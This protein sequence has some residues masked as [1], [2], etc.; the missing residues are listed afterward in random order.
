MIRSAI[1]ALIISMGFVVPSALA[2]PKDAAELL[3]KLATMPGLSAS[4]EE[5][6]TLKLLR[7]PLVST[8][9]LYFFK[10]RLTRV[11]QTPKPS[12]VRIGPGG[13]TILDGSKSQRVDLTGRPEIDAF[14]RSFARLLGGDLA[15][16]TSDFQM[17][18]STTKN[19]WTL[20]LT[21]RSTRLLKLISAIELSGV[22]YGVET[23]VVRETSGNVS[24]TTIRN[25]DPARQFT[26]AEQST[27][28]G[29]KAGQPQ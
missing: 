11:T 5:H 23:I 10:G 9:E 27:L 2:Q 3:T 22:G 1:F 19:A 6:K 26:A 12:T 25:A 21:P 28:F 15:G 17:T 16:L 4:F 14:V 8:G 20:G 13:V 7:V 24:R 18:F 29:I